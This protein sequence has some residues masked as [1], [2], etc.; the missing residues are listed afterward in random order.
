MSGR[1]QA[2]LPAAMIVLAIALLQAGCGDDRQPLR[3]ATATCFVEGRVARFT[4]GDQG[5]RVRFNRIGEVQGAI[6]V[7]VDDTGHFRLEL[8]VGDYCAAA[9]AGGDWCWLLPGGGLG[10][11]SD[12][13]DTLRLVAGAAAF[14]CD[15]LF[16]ALRLATV[17]A[18]GLAAPI[19]SL[20]LSQSSRWDLTGNTVRIV[21]GD[22]V[23]G[24]LVIDSGPLAPGDY[25]VRVRWR[26]DW[27]SYGENFWLPGV[28]GWDSATWYHVGADS[29]CEVAAPF[30][31]APARLRG[32]V[33]GAWQALGATTPRLAAHALDGSM[34]AG[35][36]ELAPDGS[37]AFDLHRPLPVRLEVADNNSRYWLGGLT[38]ADATVYDPAPGQ[39]ITGIDAVMSGAAVR[40]ITAVPGLGAT[41]AIIEFRDPGDQS[42]VLRTSASYWS[43][44]TLGCLR[45]GTYLVR[46]TSNSVGSVPVRA[47]WYDRAATPAAATPVTVP[48]GGGV[49]EITFTL[50]RGGTISGVVVPAADEHP[51]GDLVVTGAG[52]DAVVAQRWT[53]GVDAGFVVQ[54]LEDGVYKVGFLQSTYDW[55]WPGDPAPAG[56][57]WYPGTTDW[58]AATPVTIT[59]AGDVAGVVITMP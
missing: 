48:D 51:W 41:S 46:M 22:T 23:A 43:A 57:V 14:R 16:G 34:V 18:A 8:P 31:A 28:A 40:V 33:T 20:E 25:R 4:L 45:P 11:G 44:N 3:P 36:C 26:R 9:S 10:F 27:N 56:V 35:P 39:T 17:Q 30:A 5:T 24:D 29:V 12:G 42:L 19:M 13:A 32:H 37:F 50:E 54:G 53:S 58:A 6:E 38:E 47:Q 59:A 15:F 49:V 52:D 1:T 21:D 55:L 7:P 2:W